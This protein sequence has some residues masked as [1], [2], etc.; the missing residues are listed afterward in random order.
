[1]DWAGSK[2]DGDL[3]MASPA[4]HIKFKIAND[5][6]KKNKV[7]YW[8]FDYPGGLHYSADVSCAYVN[9]VLKEARFMFQIP[10]GH[11]GLSGLYVVAYV[12]KVSGKNNDLYGHT[13]TA[14][15]ATALQWCQT[16]NGFAPTM[17]PVT[18][19]DVDFDD[20]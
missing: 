4:Q 7:E 2:V 19:E 11:P 20:D 8:N 17:Y 3:H 1:M 9:P 15:Q 14:D 5:P 6:S 16:G 12:K 13:A 18:K 10:E